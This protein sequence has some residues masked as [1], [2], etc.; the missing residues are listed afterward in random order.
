MTLEEALREAQVLGFETAQTEARTYS[1]D[2][3]LEEL[4]SDDDSESPRE[5]EFF[6]N[7]IIRLTGIGSRDAEVIQLD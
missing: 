1:I 6:K 2:D 5:Y 3:M 7:V 4:S